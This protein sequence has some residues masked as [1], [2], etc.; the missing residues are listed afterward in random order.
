MENEWD[1][2]IVGG[3]AA[4]L[5]AAIYTCRKKMKTLVVSVDIGGQNLLTEQEENYPGYTQLSGPKL[6]EIFQEQATKFGAQ[7][8]FGKASKLEK[9][10]DKFKITLTNGEEYI[11]KIVIL[12]YGKVARSLGVPGEDKFIGRGVHTCA[13]CLTP[14]T[15]VMVNHAGVPISGIE[16]NKLVLTCDGTYQKIRAVTK[17]KYKGEVIQIRSR[18]FRDDITALTPNH[19]VFVSQRSHQPNQS[20]NNSEWKM[21]EWLPAGMLTKDH[22]L[23]YPVVKDTRDLNSLSISK[24]LSLQKDKKNRIHDLKET[25]SAKQI[26]DK[27]KMSKDFCRLVGYYLAGGTVTSR[28]IN[29]YFNAKEEEYVD[30][31]R[32]LIKQ[33][34]KIEAT[35]SREKNVVRVMLFSKIVRDFFSSLFGK[36]SYGKQ[37]PHSFITLPRTKQSELIKGFWR[38][39]GNIEKKSFVMITNSKLLVSQLKLILLRLGIIPNVSKISLRKLN[40]RKNVLEGRKIIFRH[41]KFEIKIGGQFLGNMSKILGVRHPLLDKRIRTN[42]FAI[43]FHKFALLPIIDVKKKNYEGYVYNLAV[44]TNNTYVTSNAIVHNCDAPFTKNKTVAV[45]GGGNSAIEAVELI[46]KFANKVY[47]IHRSEEY[48]ADPITLDKVKVLENVE[49]I[50]NSV[51]KEIKGEEKVT[52]VVIENTKTGERKE[53]PVDSVFIEI[54]HILDTGWVKHLVKTN[55]A[56]EIITNKAGETSVPGIFAAGDV[57]DSPYKQTVTAA[58]EGAVAGLS[59]Y[60][61]FRKL[62]GK[63]AIKVDWN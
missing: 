2:I 63:P 26:P 1:V 58:G 41:D 22:V 59:A 38:G 42:K 11:G 52:G 49:M 47:S 15:T 36:Y 25:F 24:I 8:V 55:E 61:Y 13:T 30:D 18:Y 6:M 7:F 39:V 60:N 12:A 53:I 57:T 44:D 3:G 32:Q 19:P 62:E 16:K 10:N 23:I 50:T 51:V 27:I 20:W 46:S 5:T 45:V 54:G 40:E 9:I 4:G 17:R 14:N 48:R 21:P 35:I 28:G 31:V 56:G 43:L 34:F 33:I 29:F 37:L